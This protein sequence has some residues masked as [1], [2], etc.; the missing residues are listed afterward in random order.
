M[1]V[2]F[3]RRAPPF[4]EHI[5]AYSVGYLCQDPRPFP[6][7]S[8]P[9][10]Y[11]G[12]RPHWPS[13]PREYSYQSQKHYKFCPQLG[14]HSEGLIPSFLGSIVLCL[15]SP[16]NIARQALYLACRAL[17]LSGN[18]SKSCD[19]YLSGLS[20]F[21]S[22]ALLAEVKELPLQLRFQFLAAKF[23]N[24]VID[25]PTAEFLFRLADAFNCRLLL[26]SVLSVTS[27]LLF[28][29]R[30]WLFLARV[31]INPIFF[32]PTILLSSTLYFLLHS[33]Y[34]YLFGPLL[35]PYWLSKR[36]LPICVPPMCLTNNS[37]Y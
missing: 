22:N 20:D 37:D 13:S 33:S 30:R 6:N 25:Q 5:M 19:S 35:P 16:L 17:K 18:Y 26:L 29:S 36:N 3:K 12:L 34:I 23:Q 10:Y 27:L 7:P 15:E 31:S 4:P 32:L 21:H 24:S 1:M 9:Q 8:H 14:I 2:F 11:F 28:S